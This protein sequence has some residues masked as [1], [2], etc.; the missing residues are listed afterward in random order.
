MNTNDLKIEDF[1][2]IALCIS[3]KNYW[4]GQFKNSKGIHLRPPDD[5]MT[6]NALK[7]ENVITIAYSL[8]SLLDVFLGYISI[9]W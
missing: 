2:T 9:V 4:P 6:T 8:R 3:N 7:I 5:L 1:I